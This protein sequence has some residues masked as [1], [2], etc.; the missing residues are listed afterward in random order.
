MD[1]NVKE[2]FLGGEG[3]EKMEAA[4]K[5]AE[6]IKKLQTFFKGLKF[7]LGREIPR[8][9]LVFMIRAF[10]GEAS[11]DATVAPGSTYE[12]DDKSITHQICD[13]PRDT[14][15]MKHVDRFYIQ[16]QWVFDSI[17]R[18]ELL[19]VHK[20]FV[21]EALPP[22]LSPFVSEDRRVGDYI[23]PE[24]KEMLGLNEKKEVGSLL[25]LILRI[26]GLTIYFQVL[27]QEKED[28]S[29]EEESEAEEEEEAE[30]ESDGEE[31]EGESDEAE[32][33]E[34]QPVKKMKVER[35]QPEKVDE[36]LLKKKM[37]DEETRL[38][39]MMIP[40]KH[41]GLY[42]SMTKARKKRVQEAKKLERKRKYLDENSARDAKSAKKTKK[43]A[44]A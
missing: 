30:E 35:G 3:S 38:R 13:R 21:G 24:E 8:E 5:E 15:D 25:R 42:Q 40:R 41:R 11:W 36:N 10:G 4:K 1:K 19:P 37:E 20:Y 22:H 23:P 17:N 18:R 27:N 44:K 2:L 32:N 6:Q 29:E 39:V 31:E 33:E 12:I 43:A 34:E 28:E 14:V 26:V 9:P 7:F 16:P